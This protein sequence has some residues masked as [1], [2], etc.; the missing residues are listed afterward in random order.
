MPSAVLVIGAGMITRDLILPSLY[1]LQRSG[2]IGGITVTATGS[3]RIRELA[4]DKEIAAAFPGLSFESVPAYDSDPRDRNPKYYR[5]ALEKLP[6]GNLVVV[7]IP[8]QLH[9]QVVLECLESG[10]HILCVKP[11][12]MTYKQAEEVRK[13]AFDAGLFV[14]VEYHKRFDR[15]ALHARGKYREGAF[16]EFIM[17]EA[18]LIEPY[19]YRHSNFQNWFTPDQTD[20]FVY[21]GCHYVDQ[22]V[23]ITGILPTSVSVSGVHRRFPNGNDAFMWANG[24]V[25]FENGA[26]LS[27]INGLGYPD[28][29]AGSNEQCMTMFCEGDGKTGLIKHNDQ[30]R[31]VS[32]S[33]VNGSGPGGS[34]FNFI[35]PDFFR[36]VPWNGDGGRPVG[37]GFDSI[38]ANVFA[39]LDIAAEDELTLRQKKIREID[40]RGLIATPANSSYNEL[41]TEAARISITSEG[42]WVDIEYGESPRVAAR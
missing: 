13:K 38:E 14:G 11:L 17:A 20:P 29:G 33:Y 32:H 42:A 39:F 31:G 25:M 9:N 27:T 41:V 30:F 4:D 24:R 21:I 5:Q 19:Y 15:R 34:S 6:P 22:M 35:N 18:K 40:Q 16:G 12:V 2:K 36:I 28:D 1:H 10:Q 3:S 26:L 7:A 8:D 23:F 37:Y